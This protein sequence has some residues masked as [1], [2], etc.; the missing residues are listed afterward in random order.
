MSNTNTVPENEK[1]RAREWEQRYF[2]QILEVSKA[3]REEYEFVRDGDHETLRIVKVA[4]YARQPLQHQVI[5]LP[6]S[7]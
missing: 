6:K 1:C 4:D 5:V 7:R 3:P 2:K